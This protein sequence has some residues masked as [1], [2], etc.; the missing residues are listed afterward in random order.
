MHF[1]MF[2]YM[3]F[4]LELPEALSNTT[5]LHGVLGQGRHGTVF[6]ASLQD[7]APTD[8]VPELSP[9]VA[10]K[11]AKSG[12]SLTEE[13]EAL[14][15]FAH[16]SVVELIDSTPEAIVIEYCESGTLAGRL[17]FAPPVRSELGQQL[18]H[19]LDAVEV[20]HSAGW[21][22]G[23]ITPANIGLRRDGSPA[24]L[25][26][27]T[28][29]CADGSALEQGTEAYSGAIRSAAP[30]V[31][32]RSIAAIL[33]SALGTP[34][35]WDVHG[36]ALVDRLTGII[37]HL[38]RGESVSLEELRSVCDALASASLVNSG[39][40]VAAPA[41]SSLPPTTRDYGPGPGGGDGDETSPSE[42]TS[43]PLARLA[44]A[45][46]GLAIAAALA[47]QLFTGMAPTPGAP[48]PESRP[49][50]PALTTLD[51]AQA[52]WSAGSLVRN[53]ADGPTTWSVGEAEDLAAIGDWNC[54]G[55]P[56]L[57]VFRPANNA[58]FTFDS[59]DAGATSAVTILDARGSEEGNGGAQLFV[60]ID[61]DGCAHPVIG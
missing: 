38:D 11:V 40:T 6:L 26:F 36:L 1:D 45:A 22:H 23:D 52:V 43:I 51:R 48:E 31:D 60:D 61:E 30:E 57:G 19:V 4:E 39:I 13:A 2:Q 12:C 7:G 29:R 32:L 27:S 20:I 25:D 37:E 35:R 24:L 14:T 59:W 42:P 10:I 46:A 55:E 21:I 28:A 44:V 15:R 56:T 9:Q 54:D 53:S 49:L 47:T 16:P 34:D 8:L 33:L 3:S 58:W 5:T 18:L 17:R 41:K 50:I